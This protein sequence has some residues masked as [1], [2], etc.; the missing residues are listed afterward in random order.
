MKNYIYHFY[1]INAQEIHLKDGEYHF[2]YNGFKYRVIKYNESLDELNKSYE[3]CMRLLYKGVYCNQILKTKFNTIWFNYGKD[4]YILIKY[5]KGLDQLVKLEDIISFNYLV[6]YN[7]IS[8][9]D[10]Q[11][12]V[13]RGNSVISANTSKVKD[14][15]N[16]RGWKNL[17]IKKIDYFEYQLNQFGTHYKLLKNSY[18]Y[19]SGF[20]ETAIIMLNEIKVEKLCIAHKRINNKSN[21][22][23]L[24]DPF[25]MV[26]DT[27]IRDYAEYYKSC[28][29]TDK[30][31]ACMKKILKIIKD[32]GDELVL[33]FVRILYPTFYFDK[34]EEI[35]NGVIDEK[36]IIDEINKGKVYEN[37]LK[38]IYNL[39]LNVYKYNKKTN[40]KS[41]PFVDWLY[42]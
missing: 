24:Y 35:M 9:N 28:M 25:N 29:F 41:F 36:S 4:N 11:L 14:F 12:G 23:N 30:E 15:Y 6:E 7:R 40:G 22:Y 3:I 42:Q 38:E 21:L 16:Y 39:I 31:D 5:M 10:T 13:S 26:V 33:F 1:N 19:F 20:V 32:N 18:A 8:N 27:K 34:F 2:E 37:K 17:W